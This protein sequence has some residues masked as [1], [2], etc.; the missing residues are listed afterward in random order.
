MTGSALAKATQRADP[1]EVLEARAWARAYLH[2]EGKLDLHAAVDVLQDAAAAGGLIDM[3]GQDEIQRILS[4]VFRTTRDA[5]EHAEN[6][7]LAT[8][9][10]CEQLVAGG[11]R[12]DDEYEGLS[13][14]FARACRAADEQQKA[15]SKP[16]QRKQ[17]DVA[18]STIDAFFYVLRLD[19]A[20]Y[21]TK[22]LA[23][24]PHDVQE[25]HKVWERKCSSRAK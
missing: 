16:R 5:E 6:A 11:D 22:W 18:A 12:A 25:L 4:D 3:V 23:A 15:R 21:L 7:T 8:I 13:T 17:H 1:F 10:E 20:E 24:H 9:I 14:S 2:A 19:D